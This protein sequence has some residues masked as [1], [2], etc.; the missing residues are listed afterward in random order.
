[1]IKTNEKISLEET[2]VKK[3]ISIIRNII[4]PEEVLEQI[5]P[6]L[7]TVYDNR[8]IQYENLKNIHNQKSKNK[9]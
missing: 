9:I 8:T 6:K 2:Q 4:K 7:K 5:N 3:L 1:M